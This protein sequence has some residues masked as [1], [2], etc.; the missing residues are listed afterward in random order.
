LLV[1]EKQRTA[2]IQKINETLSRSLS[3]LAREE[4]LNNFLEQILLEIS[5]TVQADL[6]HL[7]VLNQPDRMLEVVARVVG[8]ELVHNSSP[9]EPAIFSTPFSADI[10]PLFTM[11]EEQNQF[12]IVDM[13]QLTDDLKAIAWP[14]G[15]DLN[16]I[17]YQFK[18]APGQIVLNGTPVEV[19]KPVYL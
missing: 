14:D 16:Q 7:L 1:N 5:S 10:T 6:A 13:T 8:G 18:V 15:C 3:W 2:E 17:L 12:L 19:I 11:I 4:N 9:L